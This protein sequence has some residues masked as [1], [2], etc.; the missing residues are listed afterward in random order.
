MED[1]A[2]LDIADRRLPRTYDLV[3]AYAT[4]NDN[5]VIQP[6]LSTALRIAKAAPR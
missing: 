3:L 2:L 4:H 5:P 6:F 1:V